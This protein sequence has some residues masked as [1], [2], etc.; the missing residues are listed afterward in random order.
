MIYFNRN[1]FSL[2]PFA[3]NCFIL[4]IIQV[5][6][7][8][9]WTSMGKEVAPEIRD[10]YTF[11]N[12]LLKE[13]KS[14]FQEVIEISEVGNNVNFLETVKDVQHI[15]DKKVMHFIVNVHVKNHKF[16]QFKLRC[17]DLSQRPFFRYDSDGDTHRNYDENIPFSE[18]QVP[19][20]HFHFYND[21]GVNIAYKTTQLLNEAERKALED[22][23]LCI[24]HYCNEANIRWKEEDFPSISILPATLQLEVVEE[25]PNSN[26]NFI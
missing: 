23:N 20:P 5:N 11:Y 14:I 21:K 15:S 17:K 25:D 1:F 16:F 10:N 4:G 18:Q 6:T 22:I 19:T 13:R 8:S 7:K 3:F 9:N 2:I 12:S 26:V 24:A